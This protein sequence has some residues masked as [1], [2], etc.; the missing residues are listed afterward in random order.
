MFPPV[1]STGL[2]GV[3]GGVES[4]AAVSGSEGADSWHGSQPRW[5]GRHPQAQGLCAGLGLG[6]RG[7]TGQAGLQGW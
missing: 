1:S 4:F 6:K 5:G 2:S 3:E 7:H